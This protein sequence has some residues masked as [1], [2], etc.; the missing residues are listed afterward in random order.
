MVGE[1]LPCFLPLAHKQKIVYKLRANAVKSTSTSINNNQHQQSN[2][3]HS[4]T[5]LSLVPSR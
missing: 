5:L 2:E 1:E 3:I 4:P